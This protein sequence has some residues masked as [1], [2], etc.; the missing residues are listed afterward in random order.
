MFFFRSRNSSDRIRALIRRGV[1]L[2]EQAWPA[3]PLASPESRDR[4]AAEVLEFVREEMATMRRPHG[5]DQVALALSCQD[6]S[7][8]VLC[9]SSLGVVRP[10]DF[11]GDEAATGI[12]GFMDD[13]AAV[14]AGG[15]IE[16]AAAL[17]CLGDIAYALAGSRAA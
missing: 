4:L 3:P 7:G 16:V 14:S 2:R 6:A 17:V 10:I 12:R 1:G 9:S 8:R 13:A 15:A 11:Y 5:I